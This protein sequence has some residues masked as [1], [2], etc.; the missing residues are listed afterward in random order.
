MYREDLMG[1]VQQYQQQD[2]EREEGE[3]QQ[4][5]QQHIVARNP[6]LEILITE[7]YRVSVNRYSQFLEI[8]VSSSQFWK[9]PFLRNTGFCNRRYQPVSQKPAVTAF[10]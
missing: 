4:D 7:K 3:Q 2:E 6:V 1:H 9:L 8:R 10:L 5:P